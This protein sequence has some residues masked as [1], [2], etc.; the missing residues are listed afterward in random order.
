MNSVLQLQRR[1]QKEVNK[2][3][4]WIKGDEETSNPEENNGGHEKVYPAKNVWLVGLA[5]ADWTQELQ[6]YTKVF[7][8]DVERHRTRSWLRET[9][10]VQKFEGKEKQKPK[11]CIKGGMEYL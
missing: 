3:R 7:K 9:L 5:K 8:Q 11:G 1:V 6:T 10:I 2:C 4:V